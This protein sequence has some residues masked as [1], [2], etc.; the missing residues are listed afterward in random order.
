MPQFHAFTSEK[1]RTGRNGCVKT[2]WIVTGQQLNT[3]LLIPKAIKLSLN[4]YCLP[5]H[6]TVYALKYSP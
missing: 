2:P 4:D 6:P 1:L 5:A 3:G